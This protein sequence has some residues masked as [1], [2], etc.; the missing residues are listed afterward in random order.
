MFSNLC[1][2]GKC[3]NVFGMFRCICDK[4]FVLD[5]SG[6]NYKYFCAIKCSINFHD[7]FQLEKVKNFS[8]KFYSSNPDWKQDNCFPLFSVFSCIK[9]QILDLL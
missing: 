3:E 9:S 1:V 5:E 6:G 2:Y 8:H 7:I 4:G